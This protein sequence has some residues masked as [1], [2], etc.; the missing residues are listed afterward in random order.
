MAELDRNGVA[1]VLTADTAVQG[2]TGCLTV[3][4]SHLHQLAHAVLVQL[5]EG[6]VFEDLSFV[7]SIQELASVVTGEAVSHLGQVVGAEAEE[8]SLDRKSVV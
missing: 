7:V 5:S 8:L 2:G 6:I 4:N 3:G 1:A